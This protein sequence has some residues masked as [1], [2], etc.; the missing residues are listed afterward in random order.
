MIELNGIRTVF[1]YH[2]LCTYQTKHYYWQCVYHEENMP[3]TCTYM[4]V[5]RNNIHQS[6]KLLNIVNNT[7][8]YYMVGRSSRCSLKRNQCLLS[9]QN[10]KPCV[11]IFTYTDQVLH[12]YSTSLKIQYNIHIY[13]NILLIY[14]K[15]KIPGNDNLSY[16]QTDKIWPKE[17]KTKHI[18]MKVYKI[19]FKNIKPCIK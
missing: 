10:I 18:K 16:V 4:H 7:I 9:I 13:V 8:W 12:T 15:K 5:V 11:S 3:T 14:N 6:L 19:K 2:V 17:M 1:I